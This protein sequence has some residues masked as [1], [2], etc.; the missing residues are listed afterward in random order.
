M[1]Q[2]VTI[3][4]NF[5]TKS[6]LYAKDL[7]YGV[8]YVDSDGDLCIGVGNGNFP[9]T[10]YGEQICAVYLSPELGFVPPAFDRTFIEVKSVNITFEV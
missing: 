2:Q 10:E 1:Q 7:K 5:E 4:S 3:S 9:K 6:E 8:F